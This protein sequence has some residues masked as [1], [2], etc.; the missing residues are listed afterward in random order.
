MFGVLVLLVASLLIVGVALVSVGIEE[1]ESFFVFC[2]LVFVII[3]F[4]ICVMGLY[5]LCYDSDTDIVKKVFETSEDLSIEDEE[6]AQKN[7][8]TESSQNENVDEICVNYDNGTYVITIKEE[9]T[10][11]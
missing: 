2:G 6:V 9:Y 7:I 10:N 8:V 5:E 11:E 4:V 1:G 3:L